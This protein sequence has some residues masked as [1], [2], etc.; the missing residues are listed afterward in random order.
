M[1]TKNYDTI[2]FDLDGTLTD[3]KEGLT[4]CLQYSLSHFGIE[5]EL[6]DL[7]QFIGPPMRVTFSKHFGLKDDEMDIALL[8]ARDYYSEK[9]I[10][11]C[12]IFDGIHKMLEKLKSANKI[13]AIATS[14]PTVYAIPVLEHF[15][16]KKYFSF[17]S[18]AELDGT[19]DAKAEV[20]LHA[21]ENLKIKPSKNIVMVG[22]REFDIIGAKKNSID[23]I[24]VLY[25]YGT[26]EELESAG[27]K[28]MVKT[29]AELTK[30][31]L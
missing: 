11:E 8:R 9:G 3:P 14:K 21:L 28:V 2:F 19:R 1:I 12:D 25:G 4:K 30:L 17:V 27:A 7:V 20:I 6:D 15:N 22:D 23:H 31:L 16:L 5:T 26:K 13:L 24:G 10:F 29:V 18:G